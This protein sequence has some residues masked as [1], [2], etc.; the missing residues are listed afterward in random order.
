MNKRE[1]LENYLKSVLERYQ[2]EIISG[3]NFLT[4]STIA[5]QVA[6]NCERVITQ[7]DNES[8]DDIITKL[9]DTVKERHNCKVNIT[10][11]YYE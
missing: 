10:I 7:N 8:V 6:E 5:R 2:N 9:R 3:T 11:S 4:T 1:E